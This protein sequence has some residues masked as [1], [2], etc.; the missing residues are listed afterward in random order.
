[1]AVVVT[2]ASGLVGRAAVAA[3]AR[4]FP[5]VRGLV[6]RREVAEP[7]RALGAKVAVGDIDDLG[8]L[9]TV[10][11][12]A[13]TVCHLVGGLNF[14]D[15]ASYEQA[16][17]VSVQRALAAARRANVRRFL[18]LSYVGADPG[19]ANPFLRAK[20]MAEREI[21]ASGLEHA[22]VRSTHIY[23][24][25][26][27]WFADIVEGTTRDPALVVGSGEQVVAPVF[28]DDVAGVLAAADDRSAP[29]SGT[30]GLEGPERLTAD[31]FADL[32]AEEPREKRHLP[33]DRADELSRLLDRPISG[34]AVEV[35]ANDS[36][37]DDADAAA[38]FGVERTPLRVGLDRTM[39]RAFEAGLER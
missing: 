24:V 10:M 18:F 37:A 6:R 35:M 28:V 23:G 8:T 33:P 14:P 9:E 17:L 39:E 26:G 30:W 16:N 4:R 19:A 27:E 15:E 3:F 1:M 36:L 2:G 31:A 20:G 34:T 12:G 7:L 11:R 25:G 29:V 21:A 32:L 38:E 13:H 5:G 22:I